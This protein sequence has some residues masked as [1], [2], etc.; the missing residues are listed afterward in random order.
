MMAFFKGGEVINKSSSDIYYFYYQGFIVD[1][2]KLW[3][4]EIGG[5]EGNQEINNI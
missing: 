5:E 1:G 3:N 4:Q 2:F